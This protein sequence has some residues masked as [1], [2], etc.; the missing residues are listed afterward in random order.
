MGAD[1]A[2]GEALDVPKPW[3]AAA[4]PRARA[5]RGSR[6]GTS[7]PGMPDE[8]LHDLTQV[9]AAAEEKRS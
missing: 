2:A 8:L 1:E 4:L 5:G 3:L 7:G 6:R 9:L